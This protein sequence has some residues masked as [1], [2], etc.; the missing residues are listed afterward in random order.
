M[1]CTFCLDCIHACPHD[2]IGILAE[3]PGRELWRDRFRSGLGR[4][5]KLPD[6]A[7]LVVVLV[8]GAF[9]N[10]AGM[11]APVLEWQEQLASGLGHPLLVTSLCYGLG[12]VVLPLLLVGFAAAVCR[13][14]GRLKASWLET[15]TRFS[16]AL[17]PLGFGMWLAHY[18]FHFLASY[19]ALTPAIERFAGDLG[20][21]ILGEPEWGGA[22]CRPVADWLPRLEILF[23]DLGLLCSLYVGFR[24]ARTQADGASRALKAFSP[25]AVLIVLLFAAGVWIVLQPMQM[26]GT[27]FLGG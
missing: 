26:R 8:F 16:Y 6:L 7:A 5:V 25:W 23:L 20:W 17:V 18:S 2:N 15:A 27:M 3:T 10:A 22:C 24:I 14:S 19:D 9:A 11:V 13:W 21:T 4:F 12:L 1:D